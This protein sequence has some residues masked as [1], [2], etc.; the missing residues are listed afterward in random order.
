MEGQNPKTILKTLKQE[1]QPQK[2]VYH[3]DSTDSRELVR[4]GVRTALFLVS[5][6]ICIPQ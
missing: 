4:Y 1:I 5:T 2:F 6:R 3:T